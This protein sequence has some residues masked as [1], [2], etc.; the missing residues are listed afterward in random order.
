MGQDGSNSGIVLG[1]A[2]GVLAGVAIGLLLAPKPG[3]ETRSLVK[4]VIATGIERL[5]E[6]QAGQ[7]TQ[8]G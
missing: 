6:I 4:D 2:I 3:S 5:K 7:E 8:A 1:L